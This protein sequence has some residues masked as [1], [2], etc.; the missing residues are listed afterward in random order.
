[1]HHHF[2]GGSYHEG[3]EPFEDLV[4]AGRHVP[5]SYT[6]YQM[7][8]ECPYRWHAKYILGQQ[9]VYTPK[10]Q[11]VFDLGH[12]NHLAARPA[13]EEYLSNNFNELTSL[14]WEVPLVA[15]AKIQIDGC[16][17]YA[18]ARLDYVATEPGHLIVGEIKS[19]VNRLHENLNQLKYY[20]ALAHL[21]YPE[22]RV[23][24]H[25]Y[26]Y[27]PHADHEIIP[28]GEMSLNEAGNLLDEISKQYALLAQSKEK[29]EGGQCKSCPICPR[30]KPSPKGGPS[31]SL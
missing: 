16:D 25:I 7:L 1:M 15:K 9:D 2:G 18:I 30:P 26:V 24:G 6:R 31:T 28:S 11:Y 21:A 17:V 22:A 10:M 13:V 19:S 23:S 27:R 3:M 8:M 12:R 4:P 29:I 20:Q 14:S 5:I